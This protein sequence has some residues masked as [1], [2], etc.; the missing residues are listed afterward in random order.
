[1]IVLGVRV[2]VAVVIACILFRGLA[3]VAIV[4]ATRQYALPGALGAGLMLVY[5]LPYVET[6]AV[7]PLLRWAGLVHPACNCPDCGTKLE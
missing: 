1:M 3:A 5:V 7:G 6:Y 2:P 4:L